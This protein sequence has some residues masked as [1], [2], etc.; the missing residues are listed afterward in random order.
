VT[1]S[2]VNYQEDI[3]VKD[4][5]HQGLAI[6]CPA[7][8][9]QRGNIC[10]WTTILAYEKGTRPDMATCPMYWGECHVMYFLKGKKPKANDERVAPFIERY[11]R[12]AQ[13][14]EDALGEGRTVKLLL[15]Y[16]DQSWYRNLR[17]K[18]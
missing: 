17:W 4:Y 3:I 8:P 18:R 11:Q 13:E 14:A 5:G 16:K 9:A 1:P 10:G 7:D 15:V 12:F 2:P 6:F